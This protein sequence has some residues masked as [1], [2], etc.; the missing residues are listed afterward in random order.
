MKVRK[1][2]PPTTPYAGWIVLKKTLKEVE[3]TTGKP[4]KRTE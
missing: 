4:R 2:S 3:L 1:N